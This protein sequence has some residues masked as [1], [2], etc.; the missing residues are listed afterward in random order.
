MMPLTLE[1]V[2]AQKTGFIEKMDKNF[3]MA[4]K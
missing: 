2:H 1:G 3:L 4:N